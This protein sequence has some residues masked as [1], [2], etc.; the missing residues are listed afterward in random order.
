[1]PDWKTFVVKDKER[2]DK[3]N[4]FYWCLQDGCC[5]AQDAEL[6]G[7]KGSSFSGGAGG[8]RYHPPRP[9]P[10]GVTLEEQQAIDL[11]QSPLTKA[12]WERH[13]SV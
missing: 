7:R 4:V 1:M 3:N 2:S 12:D 10:A 5:Y 6:Q 11:W 8:W 9:L 13:G